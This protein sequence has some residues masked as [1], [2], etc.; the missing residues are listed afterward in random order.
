MR[1][2]LRAQA[3]AAATFARLEAEAAG[4]EQKG[5]SLARVKEATAAASGSCC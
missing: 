5:L 3:E 2:R 1:R 4:E